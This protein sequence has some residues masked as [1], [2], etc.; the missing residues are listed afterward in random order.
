MA[1]GQSHGRF[2]YQM[3]KLWVISATTLVVVA[4][5]VLAA[6]YLVYAP[7]QLSPSRACDSSAIEARDYSLYR[8]LL[9]ESVRASQMMDR[10]T[11]FVTEAIGPGSRFSSDHFSFEDLQANISQSRSDFAL[12]REA[13]GNFRQL[14]A[15]ES[16]L[17]RTRFADLP[18]VL[19][20]EAEIDNVFANKGGWNAL[21]ATAIV[22][23]SRIGFSCD[24]RQAV[25]YRSESCGSLCGG[26]DLVILE[27]DGDRWKVVQ[28]IVLWIS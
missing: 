21:G 20:S 7:D 24:G 23:F 27:A 2:A 13:V 10:E 5:A 28:N 8:Y 22:R 6:Q 18:V 4:V 11:I 3:W 12:S 16:R 1:E 19:V 25:M 9:Q 15:D 17:D 14:S 26:G